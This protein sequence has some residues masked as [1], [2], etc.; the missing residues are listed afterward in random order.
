MWPFRLLIRVEGAT[1]GAT[2]LYRNICSKTNQCRLFMENTRA[3][4]KRSHF[5][6]ESSQTD[7]GGAD[8][9]AT[10]QMAGQWVWSYIMPRNR[11]CGG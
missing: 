1:R 6:L 10:Y 2:R 9:L 8:D 5:I 4:N 3:Y 11:L 7:F